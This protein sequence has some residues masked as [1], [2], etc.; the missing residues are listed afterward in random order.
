MCFFSGSDIVLDQKR[1]MSPRLWLR[2]SQ[3]SP[4]QSSV[5][6]GQYVKCPSVPGEQAPC[7]PRDIK[8]GFLEKADQSKFSISFLNSGFGS[9]AQ[10]AFEFFSPKEKIEKYLSFFFNLFM[11]KRML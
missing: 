5:I 3:P 11:Q 6:A 7:C 2:H 9:F 8:Q 10:V 1:E 4:V